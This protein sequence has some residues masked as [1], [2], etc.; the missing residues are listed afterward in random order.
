MNEPT[1]GEA[2]VA[3]PYTTEQYIRLVENIPNDELQAYMR[4]EQD[5]LGHADTS[6]AR[7]FIELGAGYGRALPALAEVARNTI[8]IEIN[9]DLLGELRS[10]G[11]Q[12]EGVEVIDGD[13]Q[14]LPDLL[15]GADVVNP[16]LAI[17]QNTLGTIEGD[18]TRVLEAMKRVAGAAPRGD[19]VL[20]LFRQR[21]LAGWGIGMY[22]EISEMVG[23]PDLSKTDFQNGTFASTTGYVSKWWTDAEIDGIK[24]FF[25]GE[26]VREVVEP[27][28]A[29]FQV[30]LL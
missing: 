11:E 8:C 21:A 28:F 12:Y 16:I 23:E 1:D 3:L 26:L 14:E 30:T 17:L 15:Q 18:H 25:E 4:L 2:A 20:S 24:A 27:E 6:S 13:I 7:T 5:F 22:E 29:I 19:V 9:G 10:R